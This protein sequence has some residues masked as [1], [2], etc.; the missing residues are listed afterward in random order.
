MSSLGVFRSFSRN[1]E[2]LVINVTIIL[3]QH[4]FGKLEYY[5]RRHWFSQRKSP[6]ESE[7][8]RLIL[9]NVAFD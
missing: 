7:V 3:V 4:I 9:F 5:T 8:E 6:R 1:L 2:Y